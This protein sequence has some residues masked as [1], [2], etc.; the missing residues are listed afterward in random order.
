MNLF[1]YYYYVR[2]FFYFI[3]GRKI[4]CWC[5]GKKQIYNSYDIRDCDLCNGKGWFWLFK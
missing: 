5:D 1:K 2:K 4:C 3:S